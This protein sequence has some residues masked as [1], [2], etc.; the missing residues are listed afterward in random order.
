MIAFVFFTS[1]MNRRHRVFFLLFVIG[2]GIAALPL[3]CRPGISAARFVYAEIG[4]AVERNGLDSVSRRA[5]VPFGDKLRLLARSYAAV[6][7]SAKQEAKPALAEARFL[8]DAV[9]A[10][11]PRLAEVPWWNVRDR[12]LKVIALFEKLERRQLERGRP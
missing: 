8:V 7:M 9:P 1:R 4:R 12:V 11:W 6:L 10:G 2:A 3:A 5:V